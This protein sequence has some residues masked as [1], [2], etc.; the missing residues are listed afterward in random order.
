MANH[1]R[2][3]TWES[4]IIDYEKEYAK[5]IELERKL[6]KDLNPDEEP[7][8]VQRI[9]FVSL[10]EWPHVIVACMKEAGFEARESQGGVAYGEVS[11]EQNK[12]L[13]RAAY[14]RKLQYP[15]DPH[16]TTVLPR[17][18]AE[19]FY[20]YLVKEAKP[21]LE[22]LGYVVNEPPSKTTWLEAAYARQQNWDPWSNVGEHTDELEKVYKQCPLESQSVYN[23][24]K[25]GGTEG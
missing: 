20:D 15:V 9:K 21:C 13:N 17:E 18:A 10:F 6:L 8:Q 3:E 19:A 16:C 5:E 7:P 22:K 24:N 25:W 11:K 4:I 1:P 2:G 23:F 14:V 12:A